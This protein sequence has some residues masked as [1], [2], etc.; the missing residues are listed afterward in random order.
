MIHR[1]VDGQPTPLRRVAA[2]ALGGALAVAAAAPA[3][4]QGTPE[5]AT[6]SP[7][8]GE[9][10]VVEAGEM[11]MAASPAAE[12]GGEEEYAATPAAADVAD[13]AVAAATNLANCW[14]GG[15][16]AGVLAQVTPNLLQTK[17]GVADGA[18]AEAALA[19]MDLP[20]YTI[21]ETGAVNTYDDGRASL[22]LTYRLG[23]HQYTEARWYMV[24]A[25]DA[26]L[27]DEEELLLPRP[28]GDTTVIG[29][30]VADDASPVAFDQSTEIAAAPA[31]ILSGTNNGAERHIFTVV[32]L[33]EGMGTP[34]AGERPQG[35]FVG[36]V[37]IAPGATEDLALL[38]LE[39]GTYVLFDP[40]VA[41]SL[42]TL[43]VT[44][45]EPTA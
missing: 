20:L 12:A 17:F 33:E 22:D 18:A 27:I 30:S 16:L 31:T 39:P 1:P 29:F 19:D 28:E 38:D 4:A 21:V 42:A 11:A 23:D 26:L 43:T 44:E 10:V 13:E 8:A 5:A 35:E 37:S 32:R 15:D 45:P 14:N 6:A 9:C 25:G 2:L 24:R 7:A 36:Q 41:G 3:A 40:A 34:A